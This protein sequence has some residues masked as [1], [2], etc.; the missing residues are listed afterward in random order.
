MALVVVT[1][2]PAGPLVSV[3]DEPFEEATRTDQN[4]LLLFPIGDAEGLLGRAVQRTEDG[5]WTIADAR[6]A[7]CE[8]KVTRTQ[9]AYEV[10]RT[11]DASNLT[12]L[13][14]GFAKIVGIEARYGAADKVD[15]AISNTEILK[16]DTRGDCGDVFVDTVFVGRG[17]RSLVRTRQAGVGVSGTISQVTPSLEH[18]AKAEVLDTLAWSTEQAYGFTFKETAGQTPLIVKAKIGRELTEGDVI[19]L[20][21]ETSRPAWLVVYFVE[22]SGKGTVLWPSAEEPEPTASPTAPAVLPSAAEK[23]Q[24]IELT[25]QLAE[26]GQRTRETLVVYAFSEKGDFDRMKPTAGAADDDGAGLAAALT[27]KLDQVPMARWSRM[28]VHYVIRPKP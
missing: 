10:E 21:M 25:A 26:P 14:V 2:G 15:I 7:G 18:E 20:K 27:A 24:G 8:V 23:E 19:E 6:T 16:A 22:Q 17:K 1:C 9:A 3:P 11:V 12:T 5:R 4:H 13:A 28:K